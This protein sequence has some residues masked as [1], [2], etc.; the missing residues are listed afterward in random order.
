MVPLFFLSLPP[1]ITN[2]LDS[3]WQFIHRLFLCYMCCISLMTYYL[4]I[5]H[6]LDR[7]SFFF[8]GQPSDSDATI[9]S[10]SAEVKQGLGGGDP[11]SQHYN[12]LA[13]ILISRSAPQCSAPQGRVNLIAKIS[14]LEQFIHKKVLIPFSLKK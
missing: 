14:W 13:R 7:H 9:Q 6:L 11:G 3:M 5:S 2:P 8:N 12:S 4:I 10:Y 1:G